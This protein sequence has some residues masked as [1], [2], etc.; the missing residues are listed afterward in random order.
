M[1]KIVGYSVA[2]VFLC[3]ILN[4]C[5]FDRI[6]S[7]KMMNMGH[8]SIRV[9]FQTGN[10]SQTYKPIPPRTNVTDTYNWTTLQE[11]D[12]QFILLVTH[13]STQQT[14][15]FRHGQFIGG[16]LGNY[17]DI[18]VNGSSAKIVISD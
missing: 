2:V 18:V 15:T 16:E 10:I 5:S 11:M 1:E 6:A 17:I 3:L 12:G 4:A 8:D 13:L 9:K 14:D 7:V